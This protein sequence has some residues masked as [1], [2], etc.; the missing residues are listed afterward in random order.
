[1]LIIMCIVLLFRYSAITCKAAKAGP[2]A[3]SSVI[4]TSPVPNGQVSH[5]NESKKDKSP[6]KVGSSSNDKRKKPGLAAFMTKSKTEAK[7]KV[8]S[9]VNE[10]PKETTA[11]KVTNS[12]DILLLVVR[13]ER[14]QCGAKLSSNDISI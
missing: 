7:S 6:P 9:E 8:K 3:S 14:I 13:K 2:S 10:I 4:Q 11:K 1:M 5:H 12:C